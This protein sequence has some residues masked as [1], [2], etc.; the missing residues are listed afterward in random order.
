MSDVDLEFLSSPD[1][2]ISIVYDGDMYFEKTWFGRIRPINDYAN[3]AQKF[4]PGDW[5]KQKAIRK[6][7]RKLR[8]GTHFVLRDVNRFMPGSTTPRWEVV[9]LWG[10]PSG[11]LSGGRVDDETIKFV[12][13][14]DNV[15]AVVF[16]SAGKVFYYES[17]N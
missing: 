17:E 4:E 5:Y 1:T 15:K 9:A 10:L 7:A 16:H 12:L 14:Q 2:S 11:N 6:A 3:V 8:R 13:G